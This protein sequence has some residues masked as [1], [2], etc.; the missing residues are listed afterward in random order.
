M[1]TS[2]LRHISIQH[3]GLQGQNRLPQKGEN[4]STITCIGKKKQRSILTGGPSQQ[5]FF[6]P[7]SDGTAWGSRNSLQLPQVLQ[8]K[9]YKN[10]PLSSNWWQ[11]QDPFQAMANAVGL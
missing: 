9:L 5:L 2:Y 1:V 10:L 7:L 8:T 4:K 3:A 11:C 6:D